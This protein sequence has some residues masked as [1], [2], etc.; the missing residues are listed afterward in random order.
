MSILDSFVPQNVA[1][2]G[3]CFYRAVSLGLYGTEDRHAKLRADCMAAFLRKKDSYAVYFESME[4]FIRCVHANK[5]DGVWN[6]D[7]SDMTPDVVADML[8]VHIAVYNKN[9]FSGA[10]DAPAEFNAGATTTVRLLRVANCHY[11]LLAPK[12]AA[13]VD[14]SDD[15][16][17]IV[18]EDQPERVDDDV[19]YIEMKPKPIVVE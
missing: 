16:V 19:Y 11:N 15:E 3:N 12:P 9:I 2:D 1:A 10:V 18:E 7:I 17:E 4:K 8:G 13:P 6:T 14:L 5:R